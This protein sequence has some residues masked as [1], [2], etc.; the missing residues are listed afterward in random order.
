MTLPRRGPNA[1]S[2]AWP[3]LYASERQDPRR[4]AAGRRKDGPKRGR[5][6]GHTT[7]AG[8]GPQAAG[9]KGLA[10]S[11]HEE[12]P[13]NRL[14]GREAAPGAP[15]GQQASGKGPRPPPREGADLRKPLRRLLYWGKLAAAGTSTRARSGRGAAGGPGSGARPE[16]PEL[17]PGARSAEAFA[18][19]APLRSQR[20]GGA[21][22]RLGRKTRA[23]EAGPS[24]R[25][26]PPGPEGPRPQNDLTGGEE[27]KDYFR[28]GSGRRGAGT[29]GEI[30]RGVRRR[31]RSEPRRAAASRRPMRAKRA[32]PAEAKRGAARARE[33]GEVSQGR[34]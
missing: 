25:R 28:A 20:G 22:G 15:P 3:G 24:S 9:E 12:H 27:W 34:R 2:R 5:A 23:R 6:A 19:G 17:P 7:A 26:T 13:Q 29:S 21:G 4:G 10:R 14:P 11:K 31:E 30:G 18:P 32:R 33:A 1:I 8:G 16:G